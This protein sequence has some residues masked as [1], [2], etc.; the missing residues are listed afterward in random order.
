MRALRIIGKGIALALLRAGSA[1]RTSDTFDCRGKIVSWP[2]K[3]RKRRVWMAVHQEESVTLTK[4][5]KK[6]LDKRD[7]SCEHTVEF[8]SKDNNS[9]LRA[10]GLVLAGLEAL[11]AVKSGAATVETYK[12]CVPLEDLGKRRGWADVLPLY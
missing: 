4:A 5:W 9:G 3:C 1:A 2:G 11:R 10:L 8:Q 12:C 6:L 7:G